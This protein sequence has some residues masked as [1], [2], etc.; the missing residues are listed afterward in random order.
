M[1]KARIF[2][3]SKNAM[4]SGRAGSERWIFEY[5][6]DEPKRPDSLMG[7]AGS[8]DTRGQ[9]ALNFATLDGAKAYAD[10]LGISYHV[11]LPAPK[12][13]K[14]QSYSDNFR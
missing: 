14:L 5:E 12:I 9:L 2:Q 7:W 13:L 10:Q 4:Q 8:G 1:T 11:V 3:K 6:Q